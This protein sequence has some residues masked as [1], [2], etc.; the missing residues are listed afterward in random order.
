[1]QVSIALI[2]R[3]SIVFTQEVCLH[4]CC[5]LALDVLRVDKPIGL[6]TRHMFLSVTYSRD[7]D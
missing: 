6:A 3:P 4:P 7:N 2:D 1:M 5:G